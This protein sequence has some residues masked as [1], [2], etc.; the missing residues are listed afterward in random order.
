MNEP[1]EYIFAAA[2]IGATAIVCVLGGR[3]ARRRE[4]K[5]LE[6]G[7]RGELESRDANF[8]RQSLELE[9][10][11]KRLAACIEGAAQCAHALEGEKK[12]AGQLANQLDQLAGQLE[13][14]R[15][16]AAARLRAAE[17]RV[18]H[19]GRGLD[20]IGRVVEATK[21][22]LGEAGRAL[23]PVRAGIAAIRNGG[24]AEAEAAPWP[25]QPADGGAPKP[26]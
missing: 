9:T 6:A 17:S 5:A 14:E 11:A 23:D 8:A 16:D 18:E 15:A 2:A 20:E 4:R 1:W 21:L 3:R 22:S 26:H 19:L 25:D 10:T 12:R 24:D 13:R 7:H